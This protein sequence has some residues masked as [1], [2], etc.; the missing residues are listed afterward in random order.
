MRH[1]SRRRFWI[2]LLLLTL[3]L[4]SNTPSAGIKRENS[5]DVMANI[6]DTSG[7]PGD[8]V[9]IPINVSN[10]T[11][12]GI[13]GVDIT[14]TSNSNILTADS[15]SF[16]S[17]VPTEGLRLIKSN[18]RA[19]QITIAMACA[20]PLRGN[21]SLVT[22]PFVVLKTAKYADTCT[23]HFARC[24]FNEKTVSVRDGLF[25]V[26]KTLIVK[27]IIHIYPEVLKLRNRRGMYYLLHKTSG[28]T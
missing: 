8:T 20:Y 15:A 28:W 16:G 13:I 22:V 4:F 26:K 11:K 23:I 3:T 5:S 12:L 7:M 18:P 17:V 14:L 27:A 9:V 19:G 21:G 25:T 10:V 6:P 2:F 1:L 24:W